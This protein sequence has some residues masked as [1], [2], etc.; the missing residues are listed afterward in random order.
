LKPIYTQGTRLSAA[1]NVKVF[2]W[3]F[4]YWDCCYYCC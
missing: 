1:V 4:N 2:N 3:L